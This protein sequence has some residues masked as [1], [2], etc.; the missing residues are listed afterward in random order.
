MIPL[1]VRAPGSDFYT[2]EQ[3]IRLDPGKDVVLPKSHLL[4]DQIE[5][6]QR[7]RMVKVIYDSE[8]VEEA[9]TP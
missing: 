8:A 4:A 1:Q 5:N 9:V 6:L 7:K 3:Q 2:N